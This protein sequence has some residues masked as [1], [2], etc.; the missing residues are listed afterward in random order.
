LVIHSVGTGL[1]YH[2]IEGNIEGSA[3]M[4]LRR[5]RKCEQL[6]DSCKKIRVYWNLK[7][8]ALDRSMWVIRFGRGY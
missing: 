2:I 7:E 1:L 8:K 5:G 3:G 4:K 6:L